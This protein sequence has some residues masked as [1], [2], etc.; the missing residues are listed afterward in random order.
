MGHGGEFWQNMVHWRREW[1][2]TSVFLPWEPHER[3]K[4]AKWYDTERWTPQ[5]GSAQYATGEE[6]RNSSRRNEESEAKGKQHPGVDVSGS[7]VTSE[8]VKNNIA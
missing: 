2:T 1:Q 8:V 4:K 5:V 3:Y 6:Q 7:K